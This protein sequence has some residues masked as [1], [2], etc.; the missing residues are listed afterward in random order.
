MRLRFGGGG[1]LFSEGLILAAGL[2]SECY[3]I[4]FLHTFL[5]LSSPVN[6]HVLGHMNEH[7]IRTRKRT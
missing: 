4:P 2:L 6:L 5:D 3:G 1:G 7:L